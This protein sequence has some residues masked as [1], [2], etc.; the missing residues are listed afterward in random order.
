[1]VVTDQK[2][3]SHWG[4]RGVERPRNAENH[5]PQV[6]S[7]LSRNERKKRQ[8]FRQ[9]R[10]PALR[11]NR[12][13]RTRNLRTRTGL[14]EYCLLGACREI[15]HDAGVRQTKKNRTR[16]FIWSSCPTSQLSIGRNV[17]PVANLA[18]R[19]HKLPHQCGRNA[20]AGSS[21]NGLSRSANRRGRALTSRTPTG[22]FLI[23]RDYPTHHPRGVSRPSAL[24]NHRE[25]PLR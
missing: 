11:L 12:T 22:R 18:A 16:T 20:R 6:I 24:H 3:D 5:L 9:D 14:S 13:A 8:Q 1:M 7:C 2:T 21:D 23:T 17:Q 10:N 25:R 4:H 15:L 19:Y